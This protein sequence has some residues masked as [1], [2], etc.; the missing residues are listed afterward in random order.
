MP[1]T[2][3]YATRGERSYGNHDWGAKGRTNV[4]GA[5]LENNLL[6]V[7]LFETNINRAIFSDWIKDHLLPNLPDN[8]VIIMDNA[9]FHK[10][11]AIKEPIEKAGHKLLY[12]PPYSPDL[13][14][15]EHK[16]AEIKA[17]KR[18]TQMPLKQ[19]FS[20]YL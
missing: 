13:N 16:W 1:R 3:G 5:L 8:S 10:G 18:K 17:R 6:A 2:Y 19:I 14:P 4:I 15:I 9:A 11:Q 7:N 20:E 12:L